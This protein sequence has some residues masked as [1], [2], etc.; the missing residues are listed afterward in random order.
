MTIHSPRFSD[1]RKEYKLP[2]ALKRGATKEF[3]WWLDE[4]QLIDGSIIK[5][6]LWEPYSTWAVERLVEPAMVVLDAGANMG[7][8]TVLM[9]YLVGTT[10]SVI[11]VEAMP[12]PCAITR[13]HC[14]LND[15]TNVMLLQK[16]LGKSSAPASK[17][18]FNFSWP[19]SRCQQSP[20]EIETVAIDDLDLQRLD[21]AKVDLDGS[22]L[23][24]IVGAKQTLKRLKTT[25]LLEV[26]D[27][28]LRQTA[29]QDMPG[30]SN[31]VYG[32]KTLE[33]LSILQDLGYHFLWEESFTPALK[34]QTI[35][36]FDL[37]KR[38]INLVCLC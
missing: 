26:C 2:I 27:Y 29:Q 17:T 30:E 21:F 11:S 13:E 3:T 19:P 32:S 33:M 35:T 4:G 14:R 25:L 31:Y 28:T 23:D 24:F 22:E 8:Y 6:H 12:D 20:D 7:Y 16:A 36:S 10:G 9:S 38:S 34:E 5:Q 18:F 37:S 15:C 1:N